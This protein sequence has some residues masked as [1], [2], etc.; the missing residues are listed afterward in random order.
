M[1]GCGKAEADIMFCKY[2]TTHNAASPRE[3]DQLS[4]WWHDPCNIGLKQKW[5]VPEKSLTVKVLADMPLWNS[6]LLKVHPSQV[7]FHRTGSAQVPRRNY[8]TMRSLK[9]LYIWDFLSLD[10]QHILSSD[11]LHAQV[12]NR[13][14]SQLGFIDQFPERAFQALSS[15]CQILWTAAKE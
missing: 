15:P 11:E 1:I 8:K 6:P 5:S 3:W 13:I 9:S 7:T 2:P 14:A 12:G 10:L 4:T